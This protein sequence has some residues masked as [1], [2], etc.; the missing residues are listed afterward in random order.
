MMCTHLN[1][2]ARTETKEGRHFTANR[3]TKIWA[4]IICCFM[5]KTEVTENI[6][7]EDLVDSEVDESMFRRA[8][9]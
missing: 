7:C 6:L 2:A 4:R 9:S 5:L 1:T 3:P 8:L